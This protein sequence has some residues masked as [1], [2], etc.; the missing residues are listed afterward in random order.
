MIEVVSPGSG[1]R[2]YVEKREEY[3]QFGV[4]EYWIVD[5]EKQTI[6][7]YVLARGDRYELVLK[8]SSGSIRSKVIDGFEIPIAAVFDNDQSL[9]TLKSF[10]A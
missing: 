8:S 5:A 10:L 3:F 1:Q 2:D 4:R 7:Q 9:S 6:E